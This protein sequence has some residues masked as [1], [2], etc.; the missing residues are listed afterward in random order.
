MTEEG[1]ARLKEGGLE[2]AYVGPDGRVHVPGKKVTRY[3][4]PSPPRE[5]VWFEENDQYLKLCIKRSWAI[6]LREALATSLYASTLLK[7]GCYS[8]T[9]MCQYWDN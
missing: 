7:M 4:E 1:K 5:E 8:S 9:T 2:G 3:S 6:F